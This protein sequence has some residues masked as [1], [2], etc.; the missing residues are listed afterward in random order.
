MAFAHAGLQAAY[1]LHVQNA[2]RKVEQD[3]GVAAQ[4]RAQILGQLHA[5][6]PSI[7]RVGRKLAM[8]ESTL[9]RRLREEGTSHRELVDQV[10]WQLAQSYLGDAALGIREVA[11]LLGFAH[12]SAFHKAFRRLSGGLTPHEYRSRPKGT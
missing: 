7:T 10:R 8:S 1:E 6:E 4:V 11:F 9:R 5:G 12:V 2:Q 3:A